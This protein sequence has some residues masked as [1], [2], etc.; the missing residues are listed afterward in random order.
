MKTETVTFRLPPDAK[1]ALE[2]AAKDDDRTVAYVCEKAIVEWLQKGG[3]LKPERK[4]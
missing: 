3:W 1:A 4:K 2:R